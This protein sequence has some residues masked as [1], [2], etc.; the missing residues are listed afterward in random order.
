MFVGDFCQTA[1]N[2]AFFLRNAAARQVAKLLLF[3]TGT[4][5]KVVVK[6][7]ASALF[8]EPVFAKQ[9]RILAECF[10]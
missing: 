1:Q 9:Y 10:P 7:E 4:S 8:S 5:L 3:R 6:R 2:V